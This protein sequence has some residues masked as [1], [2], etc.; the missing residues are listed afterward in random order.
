MVLIVMHKAQ[1]EARINDL[2]IAKEQIRREIDL[3]MQNGN[4]QQ[5]WIQEFLEHRNIQ[6]LS[7]SIAVE[8]IE[9]IH[10]YEDKRIEV[11]FTHM[12]DYQALVSKVNDFYLEQRGAS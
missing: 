5:Q 2:Q 10:I 7:R 3:Y 8:C 6:Q 11:T 1:Y 12:Q 9:K 4:A